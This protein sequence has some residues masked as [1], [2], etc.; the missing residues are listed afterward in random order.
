MD[1]ISS[2]QFQG[3]NAW[4]SAF[5]V[6]FDGEFDEVPGIEI[7]ETGAGNGTSVDEYVLGAVIRRDEAEGFCR[8][9]RTI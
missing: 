7:A 8:P 2:N 4:T 3:C 9:C 6:D 5:L 1:V